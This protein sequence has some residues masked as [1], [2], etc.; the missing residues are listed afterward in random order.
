ME[1]LR[2]INL[3]DILNRWPLETVLEIVTKVKEYADSHGID[4]VYLHEVEDLT[5]ED[6]ENQRYNIDIRYINENNSLIQ[7]RLLMLK[8]TVYNCNE[9]HKRRDEFFTRKEIRA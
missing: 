3:N 7:Q 9:V 5:Y 1:G 4:G 6:P 8:G 2:F